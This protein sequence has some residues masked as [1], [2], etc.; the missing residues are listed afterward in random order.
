MAVYGGCQSRMSSALMVHRNISGLPCEMRQA[1]PSP[2][3]WDWVRCDAM[4]SVRRDGRRGAAAGRWAGMQ[5]GKQAAGR[6][7]DRVQYTTPSR[8]RAQAWGAHV[9]GPPPPSLVSKRAGRPDSLRA[10]MRGTVI[11][12]ITQPSAPAGTANGDR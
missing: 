5:A 12:P 8:A 6:R 3:G 9:G 1:I 4:H 7:Q 10:Q 11:L 2:A